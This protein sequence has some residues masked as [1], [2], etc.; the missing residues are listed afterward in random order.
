MKI[1]RTFRLTAVHQYVN[2]F[3]LKLEVKRLNVILCDS[4]HPKHKHI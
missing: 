2:G 3:E 4:S 1:K